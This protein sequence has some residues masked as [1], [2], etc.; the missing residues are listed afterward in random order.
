M[1]WSYEGKTA[2][3]TGAS[4]GIGEALA[5][6][7]SKRDAQVILSGRNI[8]ELERVAGACA[9][10]ALVLP[11]EATDYAALPGVAAQALAWRGGVDILINNAGVSQRSLALD[12]AFETYR[13]LMEVDF[14]APLRLTQLVL[15]SMVERRSGHIS[16]IS[17]VAGKVGTVLRTGYCAAKH[18]CVGYFDALRAEV[19]KA[20]GVSVSVV[21]PGSVKT[22]V[23]RNA[24]LGDGGP[25]GRSDDNIDNGMEPAQVAEIILDAIAAGQRE[26]P[27]AEGLEAAA[28]AM[29]VQAPEKLFDLLAEQGAALA[30]ARASGATAE[31]PR[32]KS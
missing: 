23:A 20:Y 28:M 32:V 24:L 8:A 27:V 5:L 17:S 13:R 15:P 1:N 2:W 4:S 21:L 18:A 10:K 30:A 14:F 25:R 6:A 7:L 26:I 3:V 29:R 31:P 9:G 12:T 16:V 11:F 22:G 19:E